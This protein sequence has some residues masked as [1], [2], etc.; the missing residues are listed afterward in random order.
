M[1]NLVSVE[2]ASLALG[3][4]LVLDDVSLGVSAGERIGVVGRNG[5]GKSTLLRVL[6][7]RQEVDA[8]RVTHVGG[9]TVGMLT[10]D[11]TLDPEATVRT[12]VLGA[13]ARARLGR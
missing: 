8:G 11:D 13:T 3:T 2:R 5:G 10:Q 1:A 4:T 6:T 7:G 12:A 9:L